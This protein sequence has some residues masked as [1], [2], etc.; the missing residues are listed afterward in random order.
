MTVSG[1]IAERQVLAAKPVFA[2][3]LT[4]AY[5]RTRYMLANRKVL[6]EY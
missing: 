1:S 2:D 5:I 4:L 6:V 3:E